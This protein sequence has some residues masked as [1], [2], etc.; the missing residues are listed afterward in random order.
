DRRFQ[1]GDARRDGVEHE[2]RAVVRTPARVRLPDAPEGLDELRSLAHFD[3]AL[4]VRPQSLG[5][6]VAYLIQ[7]L[8]EVGQLLRAESERFH[9]MYEFD[10][11]Y[12]VARR[13]ALRDELA[14]KL[15]RHLVAPGRGEP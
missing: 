2:D 1:L 15:H 10:L 8:V 13:H 12:A 11:P 9:F 4:R 6:R 5:Q 3:P 14:Q 7:S